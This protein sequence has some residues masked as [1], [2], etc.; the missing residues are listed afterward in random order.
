MPCAG[1]RCRALSGLHRTSMFWRA[2]L[3]QPSPAHVGTHS[4]RRGPAQDCEILD[5]AW[6]TVAFVL[7]VDF[8][9]IPRGHIRRKL[10]GFIRG[11]TR[12]DS[13][14]QVGACLCRMDARH[15]VGEDGLP[16][17]TAS[18]RFCRCASH[19]GVCIEGTPLAIKQNSL[20]TFFFSGAA[21][22]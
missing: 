5:Q 17:V 3:C 14:E 9:Q 18:R 2:R 22:R 1:H 16:E 21:C 19:P 4:M 12:P 6:H 7:G 10:C 8:S 11:R 20:S 15:S 13:S